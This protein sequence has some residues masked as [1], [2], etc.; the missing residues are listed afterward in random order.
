[1][2]LSSLASLS[3]PFAVVQTKGARFPLERNEPGGVV[4]ATL[5]MPALCVPWT[6][7]HLRREDCQ[8]R[9]KLS[10]RADKKFETNGPCWTTA[11]TFLGNGRLQNAAF[12]SASEISILCKNM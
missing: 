10:A 8:V 4:R 3:H 2:A 6:V 11:V 12:P 9:R 1:M 5:Y 7:I